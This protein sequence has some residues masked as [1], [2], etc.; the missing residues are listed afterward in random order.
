MES[1]R[2]CDASAARAGLAGIVDG[3]SHRQ[4]L[5]VVRAFT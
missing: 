5:D 4:T 2:R 1:S 3:L